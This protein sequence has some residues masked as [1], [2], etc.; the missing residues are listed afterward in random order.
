MKKNKTCGT[1]TYA[2]GFTHWVLGM[3]ASE[4][5][6]LIRQHGQIVRFIP[7]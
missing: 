4:K 5:R 3:S 1:Y 6:N 2:D 7:D